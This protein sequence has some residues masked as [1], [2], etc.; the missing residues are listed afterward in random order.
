MRRPLPALLAFLALL[1]AALLAAPAFA[2]GNSA[3]HAHHGN[4]AAAA[5]NGRTTSAEVVRAGH[6]LNV[7]TPALPCGNDCG[8]MAM[9]DCLCPAAC[10]AAGLA[11]APA[12]PDRMGGDD[13]SPGRAP[14]GCPVGRIPPT[15]PPRA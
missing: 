14:D 4:T 6:D 10:L 3:M 7:S 13:P 5:D 12:L 9:A 11:I 1:L 15:P 2:A 8:H